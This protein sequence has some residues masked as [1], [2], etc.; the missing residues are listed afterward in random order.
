MNILKKLFAGLTSVMMLFMMIFLSTSCGYV[1]AS[2]QISTDD[3]VNETIMIVETYDELITA[4]SNARGDKITPAYY[5]PRSNIIIRGDIV[6]PAGTDIC[7][8]RSTITIDEGYTV[9]VEGNFN[10][11]YSSDTLKSVLNVKGTLAIGNTGF[12]GVYASG[13]INVI[14]TGNITFEKFSM[15]EWRSDK[16][17]P[18]QINGVS[19]FPEN[20][21]L[22]LW[23]GEKF[24]SAVHKC[25]H[26]HEH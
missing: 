8:R 11:T 15:L 9:T 23:N 2:E 25:E 19:D 17:I 3:S 5:I 20:Y 4:L 6:I 18:S 12:L 16:I 7:F 24:V 26:D 22:Y 10:V 21:G 13:I 14:G 1:E